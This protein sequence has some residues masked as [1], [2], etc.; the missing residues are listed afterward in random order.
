VNPF[1]DGWPCPTGDEMRAIDADAIERLG[2]PARTLM[3]SAG[4]AVA[5]AVARFYPLHRR[6][7][8][9]CGSGNNGGDGYVVARALAEQHRGVSA[10]VLEAVPV[11][12]QSPESKANRELLGAAGVALVA[13]GPAALGAALAESDLVVDAVFGV[14]L[15]RPVAGELAGLFEA[16]SHG[17]LPI[18]S[19]DL[20]SG[21]SSET[22]VALGAALEPDLVVTIGLPKLG[23]ALVPGRARVVVA[24]IGFPRESVERAGVRQYLLT[25]AAARGLLPARPL[26][27][28]KGSFGHVLVAGGSLG[29]TGAALLA[30]RGALRA[31]AGLVSLAA[32]RALVPIYAAQLAE[33]MCVLVDDGEAGL[34]A[35][36]GEANARDALVVGPG[37]G[38]EPGA[39][40][41]ARALATQIRVASVVDADGLNAFAGDL[42]GLR[43]AA[44]RVLTPHPG[45]AARLL[46]RD[47]AAVQADR[48]GAA[49]EL[50]ARSGAVA[51]LKGARTVVARPDGR[52]SINPTGGPGLAAGGSGDVLAGLVGALLARGLAA[53]DAARLGVWLHGAAG[54]LGPT[55]G[56][57]AS[58]L[59][60][61]LPAAWQALS[62]EDP[63]DEPGILH[64]FP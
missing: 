36:V 3:E 4:R 42:A 30:A 49:R 5:E 17:G 47:T 55:Q 2:I 1:A 27:A 22:G 34:A 12:R 58:E 59:A 54:D 23:L 19:V 43:S 15:A 21:T 62:H 52:I 57:L 16:I 64:A 33:V 37:L 26:D 7:L 39:A 60:D 9:V 61:R 14:G 13:G 46:G 35:L 24:D 51:V 18:V 25:R 38:Q 53:W 32:P 6:V 41:L 31:G 29:K 45:E 50:A 48:A 20:A 44:P 63:R 10:R 28:H 11:A 56:G 40:R 8:V